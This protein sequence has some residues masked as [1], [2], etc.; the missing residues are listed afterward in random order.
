[1]LRREKKWSDMSPRQRVGVLVLVALQAALAAFAQRDLGTRSAADLR[2]PKLM[3]RF[4]TLNT[5]GA[6]IYLVYGR[7]PAT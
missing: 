5:I 3:W 4:L 6:L 7:R 2:G 1:M